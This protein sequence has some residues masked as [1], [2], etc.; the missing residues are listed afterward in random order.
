MELIIVDG[1]SQDN[2]MRIVKNCLKKTAIKAKIFYENEGLGRARQIIV[3]N[4]AGEYI[5]WV[6][7]DMILFKDFVKKQVEFMDRNLNVGIAKGR[8]GILKNTAHRGLVA[9]LEDVEFMLN[10][11]RLGE[12]DANVLATSGCIYRVE[13]IKEV[14]GFDPSIRGVGEDMDVESRVRAAGWKLCITS[15]IFQEVRR[16]NWRELWDEYVW[17]G[18][19]AVHLF[20][21]NRRIINLYRI[22]PPV[23]LTTKLLQVSAAYKLTHRKV[24]FLLPFHYIF[25]RIAWFFGFLKSFITMRD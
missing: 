15:A 12:T 25:K 8:Y 11:Q 1:Y 4:A 13:A 6:D 22:F 19:G 2:T 9:F 20:R 24:V 17:H 7:G 18:K 14:G 3:D 16:Q 5:I 23:A 10:T 21:K